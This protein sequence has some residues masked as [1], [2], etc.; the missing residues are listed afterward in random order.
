[1]QSDPLSFLLLALFTFF[2]T[3]T[4]LLSREDKPKKILCVSLCLGF[5]VSEYKYLGYQ[6][7]RESQKKTEVFERLFE[8]RRLFIYKTAFVF[9]SLCETRHIL[10]KTNVSR[11]CRTVVLSE[12]EEEEE[13]DLVFDWV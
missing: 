9:R 4:Q 13:E 11:S 3:K 10:K 1:M 8:R 6:K 5:R 12:E 7:K 2:E